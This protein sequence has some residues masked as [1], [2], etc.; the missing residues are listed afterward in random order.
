MLK[1]IVY[2]LSDEFNEAEFTTYKER[3]VLIITN[4]KYAVEMADLYNIPVVWAGCGEMLTKYAIE[5]ATDID[6]NYI[7]RIYNRYYGY[8]NEIIV[9]KRL[10]LR[11]T[12]LEDYQTFIEIYDDEDV[13]KYNPPLEEKDA[14]KAYIN[15]VYPLYDYGLWTVVRKED[16]SIIGRA[17]IENGDEL[18][19]MIKKNERNK[20]YGSECVAAIIKYAREELQMEDLRA[21]IHPDNLPS[22]KLNKKFNFKLIAD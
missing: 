10:I 20:G 16:G 13:R 11:E 22:I 6:Y 1:E 18:Q 14:L 12:K 4:N 17:G 2:L 15:T 21:K 9:T 8:D 3:N 7:K 5:S 19:Y